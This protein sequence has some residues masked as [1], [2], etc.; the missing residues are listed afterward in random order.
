MTKPGGV[1][2]V[3]VKLTGGQTA[4]AP[5]DCDIGTVTL[6]VERRLAPTDDASTLGKL[7]FAL[8]DA[9]RYEEALA[10]FHKQGQQD[11]AQQTDRANALI[12]Q[13]HMLD[14]LGR[15]SE[16]IATYKKVVDLGVEGGVRHDDHGLAYEFI[17]YAKERMTTPFTRVENRN[18]N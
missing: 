13:G 17:P 4:D 16:A 8:Y 9:K 7:G 11:N 12:W 18:N 1:A 10:A 2:T 3:G 14:L 5:R 6:Q 15:R